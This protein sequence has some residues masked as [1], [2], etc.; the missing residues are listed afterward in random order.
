M[1]LVKRDN[2]N[3]E[4]LR[5]PFSFLVY[6]QLNN[7]EIIAKNLKETEK[8]AADFIKKV[9]KEPDKKEATVILLEGELGAGKTAFT[10]ATAKTLG[11]N[12]VVRSP[13]FIIQKIYS[14]KSKKYNQLIHID[15]YRFEEAREVKILGL[16]ALF[17]NSRN[18]IVIEWPENISEILPKNAHRVSFTFIDES[19]RKIKIHA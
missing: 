11:I 7:M 6:N 10:K 18:L 5:S 1:G 3:G 8:L 12:D 15:A 13:T 19:K 14:L 9:L 16:E 17:K 2:H 4:R